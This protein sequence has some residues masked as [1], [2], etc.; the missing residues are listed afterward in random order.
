MQRHWGFK[1]GLFLCYWLS[2]ALLL[3]GFLGGAGTYRFGLLLAL[4][5]LTLPLGILL[6]AYVIHSSD[7]VFIGVAV[8]SALVNNGII[9][10]LAAWARRRN[11][12]VD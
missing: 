9:L 8:V 3:D 5:F 4:I 7:S 1:V 2:I 10:G 6:P 12:K 11:K